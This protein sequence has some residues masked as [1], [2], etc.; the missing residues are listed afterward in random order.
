MS[1][2][3]GIL[4]YDGR[5]IERT[6]LDRMLAQM[7][8]RGPDGQGL[9]I[10]GPIGLGH[11][12]LCTTPESLHEQLP[13]VDRTGRLALTLDGRVDNRE[14]LHR[15]LEA[16][17]HILR[18]DTDAEL[19]L[20][21]YECWGDTAPLHLVGD[22][23]FAIWDERRR[24]LFCARDHIGIRPFYYYADDRRF[25]FA[26]ELAP[27]L[28]HP[29]VPCEPNEGMIGEFLADDI[30]SQEE[31]LYRGIV[32]LPPAHWLSVQPNR[33]QTFRYWDIDLL[34]EIRYVTDDAYAEHFGS[35]L[36]EAVRA[37]LRSNGPIGAE[38]SGGL[39]SSSVVGLIQSLHR[40]G[41]VQGQGF[42]TFSLIFP[43]RPCD[44][45]SY[46]QD[47]VQLWDLKSNLVDEYRA[48]PND[49]L[50]QIRQQRDFPDHPNETMAM[51][52]Y[53]LVREKGIRV[54]LTG[55]GGDD[56]LG[57]G[58]APYADLL[59]TGQIGT[60][61]RSLTCEGS[62]RHVLA[63]FKETLG[64]LL[65]RVRQA[66]GRVFKRD[67]VPAWIDKE[68][69]K[70][71]YL[72]DRLRSAPLPSRFQSY[73]QRSLY[74]FV[75]SGE[76]SICYEMAERATSRLGLD[77]RH[78]FNDRRVVEFAL[79]IPQDQRQRGP[80]TK[81]VLRRTMGDRLPESVRQR[82]TKA[83]FSH[84]DAELL[85]TPW[86]GAMLNFLETTTIGTLGWIDSIEVQRMYHDLRQRYRQ[87]NQAY[88]AYCS[89]LWMIVGMEL[90]LTEAQSNREALEMAPDHIRAASGKNQSLT[91]A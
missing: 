34:H 9:W 12:R 76:Q 68:F 40:E 13:L 41:T 79:A 15:E 59:R 38:L 4:H 80:I 37:R 67:G 52:L 33:L 23:A 50:R 19:V 43:G 75:R 36:G 72:A 22:F 27:L 74:E 30:L 17:G 28:I 49:L 8:H 53:R 18:D 91:L 42:E 2:I 10:A 29:A 70:R 45:R 64:L 54:V 1:G 69:A 7:I 55:M 89:P 73:A 66:Y 6:L 86:A 60:F 78:P 58:F 32:R 51:D 57:E 39:D 88:R 20:A 11:A 87:D 71:I 61:L 63:N 21:A 85:L 5:P 14:E 48:A 82:S 83:D 46:I 24:R 65:P 77:A 47:V 44:E 31:T 25:L 16:K 90:W 56:W 26:S 62:A 35:V 3:V 81:F 84:T